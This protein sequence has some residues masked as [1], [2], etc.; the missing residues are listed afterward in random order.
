MW[1]DQLLIN[2][3][4]PDYLITLG[5]KKIIKD[6]LEV[7]KR[8]RKTQGKLY[9]S[10]FIQ[11]L[12]TSSAPRS[13][14]DQEKEQRQIPVQFF[15]YFQGE[16]LKFSSGFWRE[17]VADISIA[18][19]EMLE[20]TCQ[21]AELAGGQ[22]VL[23]LG[24]RWGAM[25]LY[26]SARYPQSH[27]T[28]IAES[29]KHKAYIDEMAS[30]RNIRNLDVIVAEINT[31][32]C[33]SKFDRVISVEMSENFKNY[34]QLLKEAALLLND[35]GKFFLEVFIHQ[36][37]SYFFEVKDEI[38]WITRYFFT[39][40]VMP[41]KELMHHLNE[42]IRV[43]KQWLVNGIHYARSAEAWLNNMDRHKAEIITIFEDTYG[44]EQSLQWYVYWRIT[45]MLYKEYWSYNEGN[46]WMVSHYL[47][48][49]TD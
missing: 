21:R 14:P 30:A 12:K 16:H 23:E 10:N 39:G 34:D 5:I 24:C 35:E 6:R 49:K 26:M 46:E 36:E 9:L 19:T 11:E 2:G 32:Q 29:H 18:E 3:Q 1:Y 48:E 28:S 22:R 42:H 25:S 20:L 7:E 47:F 17:G 15:Q 45:L 13:S 41:G 4:I 27:F 31:F 38:D 8:K 37:Y 33:N 44:K 40:G 43:E